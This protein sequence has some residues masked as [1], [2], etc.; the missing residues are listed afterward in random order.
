MKFVGMIGTRMIDVM[1]M[2]VSSV[3]FPSLSVVNDVLRSRSNPGHAAEG[4]VEQAMREIKVGLVIVDPDWGFWSKELL[5]EIDEV[6]TKVLAKCQDS[7]G[8]PSD[9]YNNAMFKYVRSVLETMK[10]YR[11]D[12]PLL[13]KCMARFKWLTGDKTQDIFPLPLLTGFVFN[14]LVKSLTLT[15]HGFDAV[16]VFL[17]H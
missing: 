14:G 4:D 13:D 16:S 6:A 11:Q 7:L 15:P 2:C 10:T 3:P 1:E 17:R 5:M 12:H 8:I 9:E